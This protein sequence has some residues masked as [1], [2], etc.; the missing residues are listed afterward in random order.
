MENSK[1]VNLSP[2]IAGE[3]KIFGNIISGISEKYVV[4]H[5]PPTPPPPIYAMNWS[6]TRT[7]ETKT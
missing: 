2:Y 3:K 6:F 1:E 4:N 5:S 7:Q